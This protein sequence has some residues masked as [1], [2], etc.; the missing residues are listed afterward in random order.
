MEVHVLHH[1]GVK[2]HLFAQDRARRGGQHDGIGHEPHAF[3]QFRSRRGDAEFDLAF[4]PLPTHRVP[5]LV[6]FP[7]M[8]V[9]PVARQM[10]RVMR[11]LMRNVGEERFAVAAVRLDV[12]DHFV[13]V[14]LR[15]VV[16]LRQLFQVPAI[17]GV[18]GFRVRGGEIQHVPVAAR[19]VEQREVTLEPACDGD[20]VGLLTHVPFA[21]HV[22]VVTAV[23]EELRQGGDAGVEIAF[24]A[25][26]AH[27]VRGGPLVHVAEAV[28]MRVRAAEQHGARGRTTGVGVELGAAH[29]GFGE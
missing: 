16:I 19:A 13:G 10:I 1:A 23:L 26:L 20:Q 7:D 29:A 9:A 15:G 28:A 4:E 25:G 6:V 17:L 22:G 11:R 5:A 12:T 24:V 2:L 18:S 21:D 3:G 27:L 8:P 14:G